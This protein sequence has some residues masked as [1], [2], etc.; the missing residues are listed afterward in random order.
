MYRTRFQT[1]SFDEFLCYAKGNGWR[2]RRSDSIS[3]LAFWSCNTVMEAVMETPAAP[4]RLWPRYVRVVEALVCIRVFFVVVRGCPRRLAA[5]RGWLLESARLRPRFPMV[6]A[7]F[8]CTVSSHT[9]GCAAASRW[10][11]PQQDPRQRRRPAQGFRRVAGG[12]QRH[13]PAPA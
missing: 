1:Q 9:G 2:K 5:S 6:G 8:A 12:P 13:G 11:Y 4:E 3:T 10:M 7:Y